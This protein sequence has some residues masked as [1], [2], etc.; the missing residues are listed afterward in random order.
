ME[1][2]HY[3]TRHRRQRTDPG[4]Y[5]DL[6]SAHHKAGGSL[7]TPQGAHTPSPSGRVLLGEPKG[8]RVMEAD[9]PHEHTG[10]RDPSSAAG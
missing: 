10:A 6:L 7:D 9:V 5:G 4:K 3:V 1:L 2:G 8:S